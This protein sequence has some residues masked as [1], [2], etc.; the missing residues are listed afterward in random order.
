MDRIVALDFSGTIIKP[1]A[2]E[3]ANL[4]RFKWLGIPEPS[5]KDHKEM[6]GGKSHYEILKERIG[7]VY[8]ITDEMQLD[9]VP[10]FGEKM[11]LPGKDAK[12]MIMTDLFR[13]ASFEVAKE[14]GLSLYP[15]G[16]VEALRAIKE[17]GFKLAIFSGTRTD[18]ITGMLEITGFP[19][20]F[21]FIFG[22]DAVLSQ[23][24]KQAIIDELS[25]HGKIEY[26]IGDK[27]DDLL[28]AKEVEAKSI[29][30]TWGHPVGGEEEAA[31]FVVRKAIDLAEIVK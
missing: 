1:E 2:A 9:H 7:E 4:K 26:V 28:P 30:V 8:G 3:K 16:M 27:M 10:S 12:T 17:K 15:E 5:E 31:D 29:F 23:D 13:N 18:I 11:A 6:H 20:K 24:D 14:D 25:R 21:D 19:V 22:Q